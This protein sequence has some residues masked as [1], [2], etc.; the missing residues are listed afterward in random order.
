ML[1]W[2]YI[3]SVAAVCFGSASAAPAESIP[4]YFEPFD[5]NYFFHSP[6]GIPGDNIGVQDLGVNVVI[7]RNGDGFVNANNGALPL[8]PVCA[9]PPSAL[10][11]FY[12]L[13]PTREFMLAIIPNDGTCAVGGDRVIIMRVPPTGTTLTVIHDR[14]LP[15]GLLNG[16]G[17]WYDTGL[18]RRDI[19]TYQCDSPGNAG[20]GSTSNRIFAA[21]TSTGPGYQGG[22]PQIV[23]FDLND[24]TPALTDGQ[25]ATNFSG[26]PGGMSAGQRRVSRSGNFAYIQSDIGAD[27]D[28]RL[29]D[30]CP[31]SPT[32]G[33][34]RSGP[35][36]FD[37]ATDFLYA[38]VMSASAGSVTMQAFGALGPVGTQTESE[39]PISPPPIPTGACCVGLGC[40]V[41]TAAACAT[42]GGAWS[43]GLPC[44]PLPC[45]PPAPMLLV[46]MT[47]PATVAR[48][49]LI[50]YT[51]SYRNIGQGDAHNVVLRDQLVGDATFYSCSLGGSYNTSDHYVTWN[52]GTL[53]ANSGI[54]TRTVTVRGGCLDPDVT[55]GTYE[56]WADG[57]PPTPGA[58]AV[59][60]TYAPVAADPVTISVVSTPSHAPPLRA[61]DLIT[62]TITMTNTASFD[63]DQ[64]ALSLSVGDGLDFDAVLDHGTGLL[65][66]F[67]WG[68]VMWS[69]PLAAGATTTAVFT[70]LVEDCVYFPSVW[71]NG[72]SPIEVGICGT[73]LGSAVATGPIA[74]IQPLVASVAVTGAPGSVGN[75]ATAP[76]LP[77]MQAV[78]LGAA[79][80]IDVTI[81]N[82]DTLPVPAAHFEMVLPADLL[83]ANPP[84]TGPVPPGVTW[85][86]PSRTITF[87]GALPAGASVAFHLSATA[88]PS[89]VC[90]INVGGLLIVSPTCLVSAFS[91][92]LMVVPPVPN[93]PYVVGID[94]RSGMTIFEPG[95]DSAARLLLCMTGELFN[96]L[97]TA[98]DG[99]IWVTGLPNF[100][101]N[102]V[103]LDLQ[104]LDGVLT[105][106]LGILPHWIRDAAWDPVDGTVVFVGNDASNQAA[107]WRS[108]AT[109][110]GAVTILTD[111]N[112]PSFERIVIENDG[113]AALLDGFGQLIR[114]DL[115][116]PAPIPPAAQSIVAP[117]G[118]TYPFEAS[119]DEAYGESY[120]EIARKPD[121]DFATLV[122]RYF[123]S[124][125]SPWTQLHA[126][127]DVARA[128][129]ATTIAHDLP[130]GGSYLGGSTHDPLPAFVTPPPLVEDALLV[131]WAFA[132]SA[133]QVF[134]ANSFPQ[135]LHIFNAGPPVTYVSTV[136]S[137]TGFRDMEVV[138]LATP[139]PADIN[140]DGTLTPAD[141]GV[142]VAIWFSSLQNGNLNGDF[143]GNGVVAP[144]D[145]AYFVGL[146]S[147]GIA[148][149]GC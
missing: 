31:Q 123:H 94:R 138:T 4:G 59:T 29:V 100:R 144:A 47:G 88:S 84:F 50:T 12:F 44:L 3:V 149:G 33:Q 134:V 104:F 121:G 147:A 63:R 1:R 27:W 93:G 119:F 18:C 65:E 28:Y 58:P 41:T 45:A 105:G 120:S 143:D 11:G 19:V 70:T 25:S 22:Q 89:A 95:V 113:K 101:F 137:P 30:I 116:A 131:S 66:G 81:S 78:R 8:D 75:L 62:H 2:Q 80:T 56:I 145:I 91:R 36:N 83:V 71:L 55:N 61:G 118:V 67:S 97:G 34:V 87:T 82:V 32:F 10:G 39:C 64:I 9:I 48:G 141:V 99:N 6:N 40:S 98:P 117:P 148:A 37:N 96:G 146:W 112:S 74:T 77:E 69:G 92:E 133:S 109:G 76:D 140:G 20:L 72:G 135:Q 73:P 52:L 7:D 142:A 60:T 49:G 57:V 132:R 26:S 85:D 115:R 136:P 35:L 130:I 106:P 107:V 125:P 53:P 102:L 90:S 103:T 127:V 51:L 86:D 126:F 5:S 21:L 17:E 14:C 13:S 108:S 24:T 114:V 23:W 111:P 16:N 124:D 42:A 54:R 122:V 43:S 129:S 128:D 68:T 46:T 139:C 110:A 15:G 79:M 38:A